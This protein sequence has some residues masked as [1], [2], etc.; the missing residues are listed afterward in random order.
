MTTTKLL[1]RNALLIVAIIE[2]AKAAASPH[3]SLD[4]LWFV[5]LSFG[6]LTMRDLITPSAERP[7]KK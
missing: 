3:L 5:A 6:A 1:A 4:F 7:K 2:G